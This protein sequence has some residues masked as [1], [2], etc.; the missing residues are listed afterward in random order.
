MSNQTAT[1]ISDHLAA[2]LDSSPSGVAKLIAAW[3]GLSTE[4]QIIILAKLD[5]ARLPA[6]LDEKIR[7]AAFESSNAY[8][9]YLAAR[10]LHCDD[11]DNR[12]KLMSPPF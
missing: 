9:R 10:G 6:Y 3:N 1:D 5:R 7:M 11:N 12:K 4:S 2:L 8:V